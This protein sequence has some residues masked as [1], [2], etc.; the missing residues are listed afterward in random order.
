MGRHS[1]IRGSTTLVGLVREQSQA[2]PDHQIYAF[3]EGD[4][5]EQRAWTLA[6]LDER[7]RAIAAFLQQEGRAGDRALLLYPAGLEF[8]GAFLGCLF[9]GVIAVPIQA[10]AAARLRRTSERIRSTL[11]DCSPRFVLTLFSAF[12]LLIPGADGSPVR[13]VA[14]EA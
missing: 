1:I 10:P 5:Q 2:R 9:S 8:I 7:S 12:P 11:A 4:L 14:I 13:A 3:L 6:Q